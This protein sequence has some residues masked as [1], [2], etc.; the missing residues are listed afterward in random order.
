MMPDID[1]YTVLSKFHEDPVTVNT[2]VFFIIGVESDKDE[3]EGLYFS[4]ID[5]ITKP[6][7]SALL[8]SNPSQKYWQASHKQHYLTTY[9]RG[10]SYVHV[11]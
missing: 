1:R 9:W 11:I 10:F 5:Y 3:E 4:A 6:I 2:P 8:H 7:R